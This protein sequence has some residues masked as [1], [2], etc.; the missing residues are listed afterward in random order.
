MHAVINKLPLGKPFNDALV[1]NVRDFLVT[2]TRHREVIE[3]QLVVVSDTEAVSL[4]HQPLDCE[5][6]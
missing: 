1:Q 5:S 3:A 4:L 6:V 2:F